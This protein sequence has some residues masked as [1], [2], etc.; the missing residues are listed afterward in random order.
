[1]PGGSI[2]IFSTKDSSFSENQQTISG[3]SKH[4][5]SKSKRANELI[6]LLTNTAPNKHLVFWVMQN[7]CPA[8]R[9]GQHGCA[10]R[11]FTSNDAHHDVKGFATECTVF[12]PLQVYCPVPIML[13]RAYTNLCDLQLLWLQN[14][15][16]RCLKLEFDKEVIFFHP[17]D[18]VCKNV[19][20]LN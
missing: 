14:Q 1:V 11:T 18:C 19:P 6:L 15:Q 13:L 4:Y 12:V 9:T 7:C 8:C 10:V 16:N 2:Q 3:P 20:L 17:G 5:F